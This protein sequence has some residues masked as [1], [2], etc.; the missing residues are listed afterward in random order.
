MNADVLQDVL[1]MHIRH[2]LGAGEFQLPRACLQGEDAA[3]RL[4]LR[5]QHVQAPVAGC[6]GRPRCA[7]LLQGRRRRDAVPLQIKLQTACG[8]AQGC[9]S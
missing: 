8:S 4:L 7:W 3:R 2:E 6:G 5:R 1:S 9:V